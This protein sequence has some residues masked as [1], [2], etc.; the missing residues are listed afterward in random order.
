MKM[1]VDIGIV[2][3]QDFT[4]I[5]QLEVLTELGFTQEQASGSVIDVQGHYRF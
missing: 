3:H 5:I 2:L 1:A 4:N